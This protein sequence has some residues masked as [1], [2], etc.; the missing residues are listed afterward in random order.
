MLIISLISSCNTV[1]LSDAREKYVNGEYYAAA[2]D[3]RQVYRDSRNQPAMRGVVAY[4]MAEVNRKLNRTSRAVSAYRNAIRNNYPDTLMY[5]SYARMLQREGKYEE[6]V[7]VYREFLSFCP[8]NILAVNGIKGIELSK[9]WIDSP[10]KYIVERADLFNSSRAEFSPVFYPGDNFLYFTSSSNSSVG[11]TKSEVTGMR[12]NDIYVSEKDVS[13]VWKRP[14][15]LDSEVNSGFDEGGVSFTSDGRNMFYTY[16][17]A[18]AQVVTQ[19]QIYVSRRVNGVWTA[20]RLLEIVPGDNSSVFA[21]PSVSPS[22]RYLWFVS[23]MP[24]GYGGKDIWRATI[25][26][27]FEVVSVENAGPVINSVGDEMFPY[28]RDDNTLFFSSD[29]HPGMGGLD[30]FVAEYSAESDMWVIENMGYPLNSS[31]DDFGITFEKGGESGFFSSNRDDVRGYDHIYSFTYPEASIFVEGLVVDQNDEFIE[32]ATVNVVGSDGLLLN[33]ITGKT[34]EYS[35]EAKE[36]MEYI[37]LASAKGF[38]NMRGFLKTVAADKNTVLILDFEMIPYNVP[39]VLDRIFYDFD[40][41]TLR[42]ESADELD[43]LVNLMNEHPEVLIELRSHTDRNGPE[44]YN[45]DLSERRAESVFN[46]LVNSGVSGYRISR[47]GYGMTVPAKVT[48]KLSE[49]HNFLK[50][51]DLLTKEFIENLTVEQQGI[52]DQI[53]RRTE[54]KV[55]KP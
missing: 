28:V 54:F 40:S 31:Y 30:L 11:D 46:Y 21:H 22:G 41:A 3:Y 15:R 49:V 4:E 37:L 53:N 2:E 47:K 17:Y 14:E 20:G 50:E 36:N 33:F 12:Y 13:D 45:I 16:S 1:R 38:L 9:R 44:D 55:L 35:F 7:D 29:G 6:A 34:G 24:G 26:S 52:A 27:S 8:D 18:D 23:D 43:E 10:S 42:P 39:V 5:L 19:P 51:G 25:T 48:G 32:G